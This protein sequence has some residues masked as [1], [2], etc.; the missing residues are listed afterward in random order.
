MD[1]T[2]DLGVKN[3]ITTL[4]ASEDLVSEYNEEVFVDTINRVIKDLKK[5]ELSKVKN[6]ISEYESIGDNAKVKELLDKYQKLA[7]EI[8]EDN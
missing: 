4:G 1:Y 2:D 6:E 3:I 8:K 7:K 5:G